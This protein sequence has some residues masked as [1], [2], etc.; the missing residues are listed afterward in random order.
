MDATSA[1]FPKPD[2]IRNGVFRPNEKAEYESPRR[3]SYAAPAPTV[4]LSIED[5]SLTVLEP[6]DLYTSFQQDQLPST[7][8][9]SYADTDSSGRVRV[10]RDLARQAEMEAAGAE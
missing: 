8:S 10:S 7:P 2:P 4:P 1:Q 6:S 9:D 3:T 5:R